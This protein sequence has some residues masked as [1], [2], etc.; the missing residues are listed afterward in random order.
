MTRAAGTGALG[1]LRIG[2]VTASAS[3]LGGGVFEAVATHA[4]ML[5]DLGAEPHIFALGDAFAEEDRA[6]L[7]PSPVT[8]TRVLGPRQIGF[9]PGLVPAL[10]AAEVDCLHLHGIWMYPS[11]AA[12]RWAAR[13]GRPYFISPHGMLDP[14][15]TA[16]GRAK[17]ALARTG[18]ERR[19]WARATA[20]HAL[21]SREAEDIL[22]ETG[23]SEVHVVP[24]A[25]PEPIADG[26]RPFP[27]PLLAYI[28]RVHAKKNLVALVE[29]WHAA[30]RPAGARLVI[31]GWGDALA[32]EALRDA[33]DRGDGSVEFV[34]PLYGAAKQDLIDRARFVVLPS[35][36][37]GLPMAI[38]E[39]WARGVPT[40][41]TQ[42]C[43]LPEGFAAGAALPCPSDSA[44]LANALAHA[45]GASEATWRD[46]AAA[47]R[48]CARDHFSTP[49]VAVAWAEIYRRA[50]HAGD[51]Q[52]S[53]R[54]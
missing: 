30:P 18:Y 28:G 20:F 32:V 41:M 49:V 46:M 17:K 45:L 39:A 51:D 44:G 38:L 11:A 22:R 33:I 24:N 54:S 3:R 14:W 52:R 42:A 23:R 43:N 21:T 48:T 36:S 6:R 9:S 8:T 15:I 37:E 19:S 25:G 29:G 47:A 27:Q 31:A 2:L 40:L 13:T 50:C 10:L 12:T 26:T 1:G 5:R 7:G 4:A 34:G 53:E 35:L 16:R